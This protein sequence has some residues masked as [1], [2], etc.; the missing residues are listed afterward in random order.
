MTGGSFSIA[1]FIDGAESDNHW[2]HVVGHFLPSE[3][4]TYAGGGRCKPFLNCSSFLNAS[5]L[6]YP[7][8]LV[9]PR[10]AKNHPGVKPLAEFVHPAECCY[11][12]GPDHSALVMDYDPN[13]AVFI[14]YPG[15]LPMFSWV[16]AAVTLY[17][18]T[19]KRG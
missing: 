11:L 2:A 10:N 14:E 8:V 19:V 3:I 7:L 9:S 18:R 17:D 16:A 5:E 1:C 12:F 15:D 13:H 6:P 4:F